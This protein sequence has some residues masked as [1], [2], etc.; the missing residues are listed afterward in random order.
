MTNPQAPRDVD[1]DAWMNGFGFH[2]ADT[3]VKQIG[4]QLARKAVAALAGLLHWLVPAGREKSLAFT[5]LELVLMY[6]NKALAVGGGPAIMGGD[7]EYTE[8]VLASALQQYAR[9][10]IPE[11]A[12]IQQY[13][14]DQLK[15]QGH[16]ADQASAPGAPEDAPKLGFTGAAVVQAEEP[17]IHG[18]QPTE[19]PETFR[20]EFY[21][22]NITLK[23]VG[24]RGYVA[25]ATCGPTPPVAETTDPTS[26]G[27]FANLN[28]PAEVNQ[29]LSAVAAAA[30]RS[31]TE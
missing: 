31:F 18:E 17:A 9:V 28:N 8:N 3:K 7:P 25:L 10:E 27:W 13:E 23:V 1:L 4:H 19:D 6:A 16:Y 26:F 30:D 24:G 5:H 21:D 2:P 20:A 14:A 11:D 22:G 29:L 15:G 12:R